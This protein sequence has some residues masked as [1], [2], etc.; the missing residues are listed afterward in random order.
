MVPKFLV[1]CLEGPVASAKSTTINLLANHQGIRSEFEII[2]IPENTKL[3]N[4][5]G[6]KGEGGLL[7]DFLIGKTKGLELQ[8]FLIGE[9]LNRDFAMHEM[10]RS[11][12]ADRDFLVVREGSLES[13]LNVFIPQMDLSALD[14][15]FLMNYGSV[16]AS[17]LTPTDVVVRMTASAE[18]CY[19]NHIRRNRPGESYPLNLFEAWYAKHDSLQKEYIKSPSTVVLEHHYLDNLDHLVI[20]LKHAFLKKFE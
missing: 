3:W 1:I 10:I 6:N 18:E 13:S 17:K 16:I 12:P 5:S 7:H 2:P 4:H 9:Y 11:G 15:A 19:R 8:N 14:K 20:S